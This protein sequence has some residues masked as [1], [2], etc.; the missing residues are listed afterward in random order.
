MGER[1]R[2]FA[3][4]RIGRP[5]TPLG[6]RFWAKVNKSDGCW[7]WTAS[8]FRDGYGQ[9]FATVDGKRRNLRAHIIAY[10]LAYGDVPEG[11][12]VCHHCDNP[13]CVRPDHLF[14]ATNKENQEDMARKGRGRYGERNGRSKLR[15][16]DVAAIRLD[17]ANGQINKAA[18]ARQFGVSRRQILNVVEGLQW[19]NA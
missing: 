1:V 14:L 18:L 3:N 7:L 11:M 19:R 2:L 5:P 13:P 6:T 8:S 10:T 12:F 15:A 16:A 9:I 4:A 17:Y